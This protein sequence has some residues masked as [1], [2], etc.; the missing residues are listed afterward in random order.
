MGGEGL[1]GGR[2]NGRKTTG[3]GDW[4]WG[5]GVRAG[6]WHLEWRVCF[7]P[8]HRGPSTWWGRDMALNLGGCW[9]LRWEGL[10]GLLLSCQ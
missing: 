10:L 8:K 2:N 9:M 5:A 4:D 6:L 7:T 1:G 3:E